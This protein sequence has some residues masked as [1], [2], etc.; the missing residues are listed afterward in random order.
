M[1]RIIAALDIK[2]GVA[3]DGKQPKTVQSDLAYFAKQTRMHGGL[4]LV[5]GTTF[6]NEFHSKTL[7]ERKLIVLSRTEQPSEDVVVVRSLQEAKDYIKDRDVWVVGGASLY[8]QCVE[9]G[10]ADELYITQIDADFH[11]DQFFPEY[12][13]RYTR[14]SRSETNEENGIRFAY[15]IYRKN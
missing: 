6:R 12:E 4:L 9:E 14:I 7:L 5:G 1:I 2:R 11:C 3:K 15:E 8:R 13:S 10:Y